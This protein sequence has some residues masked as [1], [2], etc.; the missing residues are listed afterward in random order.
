[1]LCGEKL[2]FIRGRQGAIA[3]AGVVIGDGEE[4]GLSQGVGEEVGY[5]P[6]SERTA[7]GEDT[8]TEP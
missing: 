1:L 6:Q 2:A 8:L 5:E 4:A 7:E 3:V